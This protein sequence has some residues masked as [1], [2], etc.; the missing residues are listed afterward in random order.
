MPLL[1]GVPP[2][3]LCLRTP[4]SSKNVE[5]AP[6][7]SPPASDKIYL[8]NISYFR[9]MLSKIG[10]IDATTASGVF[11]LAFVHMKRLKLSIKLAT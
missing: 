11:R 7:N 4:S 8:G 6:L 2:I 9:K 10:A 3:V 5:Y 1:L